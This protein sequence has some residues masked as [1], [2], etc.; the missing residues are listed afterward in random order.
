MFSKLI[1]F[2]W[3]IYVHS[4][5]GKH[6]WSPQC[7]NFLSQQSLMLTIIYLNQMYLSG[8]HHKGHMCKVLPDKN[9]KVPFD[10]LSFSTSHTLDWTQG[11]FNASSLSEAFLWHMLANCSTLRSQTVG[12]ICSGFFTSGFSLSLPHP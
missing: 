12:H 6:S 10:L 3:E 5:I 8:T 9:L 11:L 2:K 4:Y 1:R 7:H